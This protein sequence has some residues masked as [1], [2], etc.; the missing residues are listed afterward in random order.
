MKLFTP[1]FFSL[2]VFLSSTACPCR[3]TLSNKSMRLLRMGHF[4]SSIKWSWFVIHI[5][6]LLSNS[7]Y[8][9][10]MLILVYTDKSLPV[11]IS[12]VFNSP[13]N[14]KFLIFSIVW[15]LMIFPMEQPWRI[16]RCFVCWRP[17]M[18]GSSIIHDY[19]TSY[20]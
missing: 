1:H 4:S 19:F 13:N 14:R 6:Q 12:L 8:I 20:R 10:Y 16:L 7:L 15:R 11:V 18:T 9:R 2:L 17:E 3:F 5:L